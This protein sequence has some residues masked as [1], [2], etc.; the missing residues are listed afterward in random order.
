MYALSG[1]VDWRVAGLFIL[2]GLGGGV[3][4]SFAGQRLQHRKGMLGMVFAVF[5]ILIG[6]YVSWKG[7]SALLD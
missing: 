3:A 2:G 5:V 6:L 1:L 7:L 4:G